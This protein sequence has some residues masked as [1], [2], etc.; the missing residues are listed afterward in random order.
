MYEMTGTFP[1]PNG[2]K[3]LQQLCKHFAHKIEVQHDETSG[4][5]HLPFAVAQ[6]V[7]DD[8]GLSVRFELAHLQDVE[9]AQSVIDKHLA[10]FAFREDFTNMD[11]VTAQ[12]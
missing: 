1:T 5:V 9:R 12:S 10:R 2:S 11:W 7:A 6:L 3:Y 4:T 8:S